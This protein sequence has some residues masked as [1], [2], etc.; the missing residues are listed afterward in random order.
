MNEQG[1][2]K[3]KLPYLCGI[4]HNLFWVNYSNFAFLENYFIEVI[5]AYNIV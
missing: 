5:L 1:G 3:L 4:K 2:Y